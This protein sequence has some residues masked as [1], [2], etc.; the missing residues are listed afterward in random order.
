MDADDVVAEVERS[1]AAAH[2][3]DALAVLLEVR[4]TDPLVFLSAY[5]R[6]AAQ[7][8]DG[9]GMALHLIRACP[10]SRTCFHD[11]LYA[12]FSA[13]R[14]S[15]P[16]ASAGGGRGD[17]AAAAEE[18]VAAADCRALLEKMCQAL[19]PQV[20]EG[21]LADLEMAATRPVR[22]PEFVLAVE[23][24][25]AT[26]EALQSAIQL[27]DACDRQGLGKV[28]RDE[29]LAQLELKRQAQGAQRVGSTAARQSGIGSQGGVGDACDEDVPPTEA[30]RAKLA[31]QGLKPEGLLSPA[32]LFIAMWLHWRED[33]THEDATLPTTSAAV[34]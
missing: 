18:G 6:H 27:F 5:F 17:R 23:S 3:R 31:A 11:T 9:V 33:E 2:L 10:R 16:R 20:A 13:L 12:A 22:F 28:P 24:C 21:V 29:F 19:P 34:L 26:E 30:L 4:P 14:R 32:D 7:P 15:P 8:E 1:G 25:L